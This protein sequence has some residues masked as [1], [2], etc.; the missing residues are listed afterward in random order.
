MKVILLAGGLGTRISEETSD[1]PK[2]MVLLGDKPIIWHLMSIFAAQGFDDFVIA[3]GYKGEIIA[4]WVEKLETPWKIQAL[5]TGLNTQT[6]GR[7]SQC[8]N[9]FP[10]ERVFATYGDGLGNIDLIKL[11]DFHRTHKKKATVT[12][13][14]P[15][16]RFGVLESENGRVTHFGEKNQAD[17]GWING[18]FFLLEP[19]V[20][21]HVLSDSEPFE[22]GALPRLV[23]KGELMAYHHSGFWQPMD[24]LREK[25]DLEKLLSSGEIPWLQFKD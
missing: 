22:T 6:G 12:A 11:L 1:K 13:V 17:A 7:I 18:G 14:R 19:S 25:H 15:P 20:S 21:T 16:A 8:M 10:E 24:T 9:K 5:D 23:E 4:D 2:P 3:C